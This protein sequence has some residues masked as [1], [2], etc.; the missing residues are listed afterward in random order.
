MVELIFGNLTVLDVVMAIFT[1]I[2]GNVVLAMGYFMSRNHVPRWKSRKF[3]HVTMGTV[4]AFTVTVYSNLSGPAFAMGVFAT[5]LLYVWSHK[6]DLI[7]DLLAAGSREFES[8]L[9]TFASSFMGLVAFSL[10]FLIF[11]ERPEIFVASF[12]VVAWGDAAGEIIGRPYGGRC[13]RKLRKNKSIEGSIAVFIASLIAFI[14]SL[15]VF[16][17]DTCPLCVMFQLIIIAFIITIVE[18]YSIGWTDNFVLPLLTAIL[19]WIFIFPSI[20]LL[21]M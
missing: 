13:F 4:I 17:A 21:S 7:S 8:K 1:G 12:L 6:R 5:G 11:L 15:G 9:N 10:T 20:T 18:A 3:V 14:I 19:L 2:F 16:S